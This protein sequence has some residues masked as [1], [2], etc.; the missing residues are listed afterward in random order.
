MHTLIAPGTNAAVVEPVEMELIVPFNVTFLISSILSQTETCLRKLRPTH[1][2]V[3]LLVKT[4]NY[5]V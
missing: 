1:K 2:L 5:S 3:N 4:V